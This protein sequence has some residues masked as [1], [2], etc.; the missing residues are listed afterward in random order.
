MLHVVEQVHRTEVAHR[1]LGLAGVERDLRAQIRAVHGADV[2]LRRAHVARIL[3]GD[4]RMPGLEQHRQH[5]A[6]E[7]H[8]RNLL[9]QLELAARGL[10]FVA[11]VRFLELA[12]P[13]VVQVG[14]VGRREERPLAAFH[15]A[16]HEEIGNPVGRVH[17]VRAAA[18][19]AGV[20][21]ELQEFLDVEVPGLEI[22]AHRA[23]ALAPV[24]DEARRGHV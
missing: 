5:L 1:D 23:L 10:V 14:H 17:V 13:L 21:P 20:L 11:R 15:D 24:V 19:V 18:I 6:P 12:P 3:E 7:L 4:P 22:A 2:R 8:R 9:R 16:L